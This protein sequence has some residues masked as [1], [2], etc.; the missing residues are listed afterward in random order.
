M[1]KIKGE[2]A[3]KITIEPVTNDTIPNIVALAKIIWNEHYHSII[4]VAQIDYMLAKYQSHSAITQQIT[5]GYEYFQVSQNK[6][7]IGY[8]S[9][10]LRNQKIL[11]ISKFYL[12]KNTRGQGI[13]KK[14]L[15]FIDELAVNNNCEKLELT[16]NKENP[17]YQVY[18]KLGFVN[19]A[20]IKF[21]IG[22]GFIMDDYV[23]S[24]R[25]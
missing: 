24:K 21:D 9:T 20:K 22:G 12:H 1:K 15:E 16:V 17:A 6:Q 25:I 18:L 19:Q 14:M 5:E 3:M 2:N 23:M 4:S 13:G 10:Q 7:I 11:F 8:F